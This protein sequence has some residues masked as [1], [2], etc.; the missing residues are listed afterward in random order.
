MKSSI[1]YLNL[2]FASISSVI[3][4]VDQTETTINLLKETQLLS[5]NTTCLP[6]TT[7]DTAFQST[8]DYEVYRDIKTDH[9]LTLNLSKLYL[10]IPRT[11][12]PTFPEF[13][14]ASPSTRLDR[15]YLLNLAAIVSGEKDLGDTDNLWSQREELTDDESIIFVFS[16]EADVEWFYCE[17]KLIK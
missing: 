6:V 2:F 3:L 5:K 7:D 8:S 1:V 15:I 12:G 13:L 10:G 9:K 17:E 11:K 4:I 14:Y 16:D